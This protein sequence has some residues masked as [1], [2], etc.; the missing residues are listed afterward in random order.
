MCEDS[1]LNYFKSVVTSQDN[2]SNNYLKFI[3]ILVAN[4]RTMTLLLYTKRNK[5][6]RKVKCRKQL[7]ALSLVLTEL[8][9]FY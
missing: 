4:N 9:Y 6:K 2:Y 3:L 1:P 5:K 7:P 8:F